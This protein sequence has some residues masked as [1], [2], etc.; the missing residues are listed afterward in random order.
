M[1]PDDVSWT[2]A[3]GSVLAL[4]QW[5]GYAAFAFGLACFA[6]ADDR[7][8]KIFMALECAAYALHF[9]L[10]KP[11]SPRAVAYCT[12]MPAAWPQRAR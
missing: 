1:L 8:F 5:P 10:L 3:T 7:R 2:A 9:A 4:A 6:Q 12:A 11:S